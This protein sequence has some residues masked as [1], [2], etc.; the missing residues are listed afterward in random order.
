V[1]DS[2]IGGGSVPV[3]CEVHPH[4]KPISGADQKAFQELGYVLMGEKMVFACTS[5]LLLCTPC[6]S[7]AP[8]DPRERQDR[9]PRLAQ[10]FFGKFM[11]P[12]SKKRR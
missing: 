5:F 6:R 11:N 9:G 1:G 8:C 3:N 7:A 2:L 12:T 10:S 4:K